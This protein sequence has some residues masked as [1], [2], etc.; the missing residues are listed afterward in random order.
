M[1]DVQ[2]DYE[3]QAILAARYQGS[4]DF[5]AILVMTNTTAGDDRT[6]QYVSGVTL[7][8]FDGSGYTAGHGNAGRLT[9]TLTAG[10]DTTD[11]KGTLAQTNNYLEW[12]SLGNGTR[13]IAGCLWCK[14]GTDDDTDAEIVRYYELATPV[15]PGGVNFRFTFASSVLDIRDVV[16]A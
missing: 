14:E 5:K 15:D 7:D 3:Y 10:V 4:T 9:L 2:F 13:Q 1:A 6:I 11:H 8:E 16:A 12:T